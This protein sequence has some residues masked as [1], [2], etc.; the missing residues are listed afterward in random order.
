MEKIIKALSWA[1]LDEKRWTELLSKPEDVNVDELVGEIQKSIQVKVQ[2]DAT[3]EPYRKEVINGQFARLKS[4][5]VTKAKKNFSLGT[6]DFEKAGVE[7]I[8]LEIKKSVGTPSNETIAALEKEKQ[9]LAKELENEKA[10][11]ERAETEWKDKV[12]GV[13]K[14]T[15]IK[16]LVKG[17]DTIGTKRAAEL[18]VLDA[19]RTKYDVVY[20]DS[21]DQLSIKTKAGTIVTNANSTK[22]LSIEEIIKMELENNELL[23][24][25]PTEKSNVPSAPKPV[26]P[27]ITN[28]RKI[29]QSA[30]ANANIGRK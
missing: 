24:Q 13:R 30:I 22:E 6:T 21:S 1:A 25:V 10:S 18:V 17:F 27:A 3:F 2:N 5:L 16:D 20:D 8:L 4:E 14:D 9:T 12:T 23:K 19:L 15:K 26:T 11:R 29:H 7:D 28:G